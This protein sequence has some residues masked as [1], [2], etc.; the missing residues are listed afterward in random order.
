MTNN[1]TIDTDPALMRSSDSIAG[2]GDWGWIN[3]RSSNH[4]ISNNRPGRIRGAS[5][6]IALSLAPMT[7]LRDPW[8]AD[9]LDLASL[10]V[11]VFAPLGQRISLSDARKLALEFLQQMEEGRLLVTE[12]EARLAFTLEDDD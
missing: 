6:A 4:S 5:A 3:P 10:T 8:T 12:R 2:S 1:L 11:A 7:A 9:R